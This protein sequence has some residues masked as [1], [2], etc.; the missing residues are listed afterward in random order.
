MQIYDIYIYNYVIYRSI[1]FIGIAP[2]AANF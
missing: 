1:V 2:M